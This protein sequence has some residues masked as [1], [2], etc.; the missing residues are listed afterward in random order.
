MNLKD[1]NHLAKAYREAMPY[2]A[3]GVQMAAMVIIMFLVGKWADDKFSTQP[4]L[5]IVGIFFGISAGFYHFFKFV[6]AE[7]KKSN[8]SNKNE[9]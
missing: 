8:T 6:S 7:S 4:W 9:N 5:M 3:I 1:L 2:L